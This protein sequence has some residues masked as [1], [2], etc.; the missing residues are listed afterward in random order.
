MELIKIDSNSL[1]SIQQQNIAIIER[2]ETR[3][4]EHAYKVIA[5]MTDAEIEAYHAQLKEIR[6][7][8]NKAVNVQIELRKEATRPL[9]E[10]KKMF[11]FQEKSMQ[12]EIHKMDSKLTEIAEYI[13]RKQEEKRK[14]ELEEQ[15]QK[16]LE[17][18]KLRNDETFVNAKIIERC[19][20]A[21]NWFN[22]PERTVA[23]IQQFVSVTVKDVPFESSDEL[24]QKY[25]D[26]V[27]AFLGELKSL[28]PQRIKDIEQGVNNAV[29]LTVTVSNDITEARQMAVI[30]ENIAK[31]EVYTPEPNVRKNEI[32]A[33]NS[34]TEWRLIMQ[35]YI[36]DM[37]HKLTPAECE[38]KFKF[39]LVAANNHLKQTGEQIEGIA[40]KEVFKM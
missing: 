8:A 19:E 12:L 1:S 36:T 6:D 15:R 14:K 35:W 32:Y 33:P 3:V 20:G 38:K 16:E 22:A 29:D 7:K 23:E 25:I 37:F 5:R 2:L 17:L 24:I 21:K 39:A 26:E 40:M 11:T 13:G 10:F 4:K 27:N 31:A 18:A 28:A 30:S 34:T 9:D